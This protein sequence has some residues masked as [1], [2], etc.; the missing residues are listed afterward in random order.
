MIRRLLSKHIH[1]HNDSF[2]IKACE[3]R[4]QNEKSSTCHTLWQFVYPTKILWNV[5]QILI[6]D[7]P[8]FKCKF[9][10]VVTFQ[11][12]D[13]TCQTFFDLPWSFIFKLLV[14]RISLIIDSFIGG[15]YVI[16]IWRYHVIYGFEVIGNRA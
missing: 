12:L 16:N 4:Q 11:E 15:I 10:H 7:E 13:W 5:D 6:E 2:M 9:T 3:N 8:I 1:K 14:V